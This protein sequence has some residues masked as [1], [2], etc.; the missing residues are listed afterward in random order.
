MVR[1]LTLDAEQNGLL[2]AELVVGSED[3]ARLWDSHQFRVDRHLRQ[4]VRH[5]QV[6]EIELDF[7]VLTAPDQEQQVVI[8]TA[9]PESPAYWSLQLLKVIST[10]RMT[11][12][13]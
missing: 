10:Q 7:D 5:P 1:S 12:E 4:T 6:G 8:F 13:S 11:H 3:F 2:V 9:D